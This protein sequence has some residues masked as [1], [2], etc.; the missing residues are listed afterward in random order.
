ML[1]KT[2]AIGDVNVENIV[3]SKLIKT[4]TNS[5]YFIGIKFDKAIWIWLYGYGYMDL[6]MDLKNNP[7]TSF[8]LPHKD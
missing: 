6:P 7:L 8:I 5:K 1:Q 4:K 3:I 2:L